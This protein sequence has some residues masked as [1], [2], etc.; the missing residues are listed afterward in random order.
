MKKLLTKLS[1]WILWLVVGVLVVGLAVTFEGFQKSAD[2]AAAGTPQAARTPTHAPY[3]PPEIPPPPPRM[4]RIFPT[5][6]VPIT[7]TVLMTRDSAIA[8]AMGQ[9]PEFVNLQARGQLTVTTRLTTYGAYS[10]RYDTSHSI[11][12]PT[13]P[14]WVV[15]LETPP[16]TRWIGPVGQQVQ[17][18]YRG[19]AYVIDATTDNLL[20]SSSIPDNGER[21]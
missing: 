3:P 2:S 15:E 11:Y 19:F 9:N 8:K 21:K 1:D 20:F 18:T 10:G 17:Q 4:T 13:L 7:T 12:H 14:I 6:I 5:P 16:W